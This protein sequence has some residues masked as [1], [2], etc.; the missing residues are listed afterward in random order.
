MKAADDLA[1]AK[2]SKT[3]GYRSIGTEG[4]FS[5]LGGLEN[6]KRILEK[7]VN[8]FYNYYVSFEQTDTNRHR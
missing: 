2:L 6:I 7:Y 5:L 8:I 4:D 3:Y 1:S